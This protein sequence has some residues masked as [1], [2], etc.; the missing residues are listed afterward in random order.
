M[1]G[2]RVRWVLPLALIATV[3]LLIAAACWRSETDTVPEP[4]PSVEGLPEGFQ[5][6]TEVWQLLQREHV[7]RG[8]LDADE[9]SDGAI[10]GMLRAL[11]DPYAAYLT[12]E[13]YS[14]D[15]QDILGFFEGIGAE[16]GMRDGRVTIIAPIPDSPADM[17]GIRPGDV[18]LEIEGE[19]TQ[20]ISLLDAVRI[21]RGEKGTPVT[22]LVLHRDESRP[23]EIT[24]VRGVIPLESVRL[25]MQ[26]GGIGH[27]RV[28]S[29]SGTTNT[30]IEAA[31]ERFERS[32]G[33]GLVL[34][35][36]NN[37]GGLLSS[38]ISVTSQFLDDGL[39]LYQIDADGE[40]TDWKVKGGGKATD[41]PMVV[42]V[43]EFS[44]SASEV[45][46]G[47]IIDQGRAPVVGATTYGKGSINNQWPLSDGSGVNFTV[48]RWFTPNG[49]QIEGEGIEPD[50][51]VEGSEDETED[52]QFDRALEILQE[53]I[54][55][56]R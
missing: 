37:P 1:S 25:L 5:R 4:A 32:R 13:Q 50:V 16:V 30:E 18:I 46:A 53:Q 41:I 43:N 21:I 55:S 31:F 45:L 51:V 54:A 38:V 52:V 14:I 22:L 48:A 29:F 42:L 23:E 28:L 19:N 47:A 35:L 3:F 17:A 8:N 24:I 27:L 49:V 33:L 39:V 40:R 7:D 12:P 6:M 36:R 26:V 20:G 9:L 11:D 10:R 44:A 34:D 2:T 15:S 56:S